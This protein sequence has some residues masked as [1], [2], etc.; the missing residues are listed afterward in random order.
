VLVLDDYHLLRGQAVDELLDSLIRHW[1]RTMHLVLISRV[2][3]AL[4]LAGLRA[5]GQ[6]AEI[7]TADLRF[8]AQETAAYLEHV[9]EMRLRDED[10]ALLEQE[11]EGWIAALRLATLSLRG[12]GNIDGISSA[13][14]RSGKSMAEYLQ[15]EVLA[16]QVP[17]IQTFLLKTSILDRFCAPLCEIVVEQDDPAWSARACIDWLERADLFISPL[18]DRGEWY[19]YHSLFHDFLRERLRAGIAPAAAAG[20]H[21]KAAAWFAQ[22][23]L[24]DEAVRHALKAGDLDLAAQ[25]IEQRLRDELNRVD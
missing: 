17:A 25:M 18:D 21:R 23:G 11:A 8:N 9:L 5:G 3:P 24:L 6:I 7:R 16:R 20:L 14:A 15:D 22:Q 13:M 12:V 2:D 4:R 1:P 10:R 19:C